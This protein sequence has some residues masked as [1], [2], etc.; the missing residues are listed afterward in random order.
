MPLGHVHGLDRLG[1]IEWIV[2]GLAALLALWSIWRS[3]LLTLRPG[4]D[5]P[6]HHKRLI[7]ERELGVEP[8]PEGEA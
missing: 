4:E 8:A 7:F 3:V 1:P 6:D 5:Q 2:V